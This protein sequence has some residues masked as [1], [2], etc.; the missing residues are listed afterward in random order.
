M[1]RFLSADATVEKRGQ[2]K[3]ELG[4]KGAAT[5]QYCS[6]KVLL[7]SADALGNEAVNLVCF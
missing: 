3:K 1:K 4:D 5:L 2:E 6:Y 7:G